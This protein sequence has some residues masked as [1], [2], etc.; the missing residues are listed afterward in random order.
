MAEVSWTV[1]GKDWNAHINGERVCFLKHM[2]IGGY[3]AHLSNGQ[4]WPAP[5]HLPKAPPQESKFFNSIDDAK[6][7][8]EAMLS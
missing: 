1:D 7:A 8:C 6:Q 2:D 5:A 3:N 4:L